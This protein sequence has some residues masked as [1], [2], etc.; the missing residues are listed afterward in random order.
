MFRSQSSK[1]QG[2]L[3]TRAWRGGGSSVV[4]G[5]FLSSRKPTVLLF[6]VRGIS[7]ILGSPGLWQHLNN[8]R[9]V[10]APRLCGST[11]DFLSLT[12]VQGRP[13]SSFLV[14]LL[15]SF[16]FCPPLPSPPY[17]GGFGS[18]RNF[19]P[20]WQPW[21]LPKP[22]PAA[23]SGERHSQMKGLPGVARLGPLQPL[24][25]PPC[26]PVPAGESKGPTWA[27]TSGGARAEGSRG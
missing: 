19:L 27:D 7:Q 16:H 23:C 26:A 21:H 14:L 18:A 11:M 12:R 3:D 10:K 15:S 17:L 20:C 8:G 2:T 4:T 9:Q 22:V 6:G 24:S 5:V 1:R 13:T 25:P